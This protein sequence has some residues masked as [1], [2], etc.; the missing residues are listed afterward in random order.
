MYICMSQVVH[1]GCVIKLLY[2]NTMNANEISLC[3]NLF[4]II[5]LSFVNSVWTTS[6]ADCI[7]FLGHRGIL[8]VSW[9]N[10]AWF[11]NW[12][13][14][15][16]ALDSES[17][18]SNRLSVI[19]FIRNFIEC[20]PQWRW[21]V[22][23]PRSIFNCIT[24]HNSIILLWCSSD[25]NTMM[26]ISYLPLDFSTDWVSIAEEFIRRNTKKT[27]DVVLYRYGRNFISWH[28]YIYITI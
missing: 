13:L 2:T 6:T 27:K 4:V 15:L 9:N 8:F 14:A 17:V 28:H 16:Q 20:I 3:P 5:N 7:Y 24:V 18:I 12:S 11:V 10:L 21:A 25:K 23:S 26:R 19:E 22:L 1:S